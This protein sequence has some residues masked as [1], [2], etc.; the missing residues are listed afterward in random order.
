MILTTNIF[1]QVAIDQL[2]ALKTEFE[3]FKDD[4]VTKILESLSGKVELVHQQP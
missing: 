2:T 4:S 1:R 3:V